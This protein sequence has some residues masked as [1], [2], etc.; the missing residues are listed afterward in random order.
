MPS[1]THTPA[2]TVEAAINELPAA[3]QSFAL[4][5]HLGLSKPQK[6]L[7]S[8]YFYD[9]K[10]SALFQQIMALPSYYLTRAERSIFQHQAHEII[11]AWTAKP[12]NIIELGAGDGTKTIFLLEALSE[13]QSVFQ[14][15]PIDISQGALDSLAKNMRSRLP[16]MKMRTICADYTE[17][18]ASIQRQAAEDGWSNAVLFLGSNIGNFDKVQAADLLESIAQNLS[19]GDFILIGI[20]LKKDPSILRKA[21]DDPEGVTRAF[22][23]NLLERINRELDANFDLAQW[24]HHAFYNPARGAMESFLLSKQAT[25]IKLGKLGTSY[26]FAAWESIHTEY[27]HKYNVD[28]FAELAAESGFTLL[29]HFM[30]EAQQF[31]SLLFERR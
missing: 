10:G 2:A 9:D 1:T 31:A 12:T 16:A 30:D 8:K 20:D 19:P 25:T 26:A 4:D 21:Y 11:A 29:R 5:V 17:G 15:V 24:A 23:L 22:N 27:S 28:E 14:Y 18:L 7:N 13:A 3:L 6:Q